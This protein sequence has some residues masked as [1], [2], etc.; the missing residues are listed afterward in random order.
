[1]SLLFKDSGMVLSAPSGGA[2]WAQALVGL[3]AA[4]PLAC[5]SAGASRARCQGGN[6]NGERHTEP[7]IIMAMLH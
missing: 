7:A 5:T 3:L 2:P 4:S 1:M 6:T